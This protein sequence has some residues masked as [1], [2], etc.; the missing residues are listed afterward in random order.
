MEKI[1]LD[2]NILI[3]ILKNNAS[4][5]SLFHQTSSTFAISSISS[6]ELYYGARD[7]KE[8]QELK[9]FVTFFDTIELDATISTTAT[10]LVETYA[11]SHNLTIPDALIAATALRYDYPLWTLNMKDFHYIDGLKLFKT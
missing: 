9:K 8:L 6:M 4:I 2:T 3:E 1:V 11:K 7:K 10:S 5:V